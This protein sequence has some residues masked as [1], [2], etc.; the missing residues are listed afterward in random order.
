M[1]RSSKGLAAVLLL[2]LPA[3]PEG[4]AAGNDRSRGY[5]IGCGS[6]DIT[7]PVTGVP[8]WGFVRA[9]QIGRGL[10][11]RQRAR[12]FLVIDEHDSRLVLIVCD[13]GSITQELT[14]E[15]LDRLQQEFGDLY[16]QRNVILSA[17]HTHAAPAGFW[18]AGVGTPFGTPFYREYF[19]NIVD[20]VVSAVRHAHRTARP[21]RILLAR[22]DVPDAGVN[23]SLVAYM[24]N[25]AEERA[26]YSG[27]TDTTMT[28][29]RFET[30][31]GPIGCLNWFAVHPTTMTYHNRLVSGDNKG[32]AERAF[33]KA[34]GV[35]YR[36][37]DDFV[38]AFAQSNCGDVTG[39]LNL[40]NTGPGETEFETTRIIGHRQYAVARELFEQAEDELHGP[41]VSRQAWVDLS[42]VRVRPEFTGGSEQRTAPAAWGYAFAAGSTEDG[43]GHPLFREGMTEPV[44]LLE[45]TL[46]QQ[47]PDARPDEQLR[48]LHA[49]KAILLAPGNN[50]PQAG[51][52]RPVSLTVARLGPLVLAAGPAEFT[53]MAGR[54][55]RDTLR[56]VCG[57]E[58]VRDVVIA[59]YSNGYAGYVTTREEYETQQYE[60]GHTL[61]GPWTLAA[62]RQ[63]FAALA[64]SLNEDPVETPV[65]DRFTDLRG[66]VTSAP[67]AVG[68]DT[69]PAAGQFGD[70][71]LPPQSAYRRGQTVTVSFRTVNPRNHY[72]HP[73][74]VRVERQ[75]AAG[76]TTAAIDADWSVRVEFDCDDA[77]P[78]A[79]R[80]TVHWTPENDSPVGTCRIVHTGS[81]RSEADGPEQS[82]SGQT[83][84]F[85]LDD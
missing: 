25:P 63:E 16:T 26:R 39:N 71:L 21:G 12:A 11:L 83:E 74:F 70:V 84:P 45:F 43:G 44:P 77:S 13:L 8:F 7:G 33:E 17:T 56:R 10:H 53:T 4:T 40:D 46:D 15:V 65:P 24:N 49:P 79:C 61:F 34:E 9:D 75:E 80:M 27:S 18:H 72:P 82:F 57:P 37:P 42:C 69:P 78:G 54:R 68:P 35:L 23:R 59:G 52:G 1:T 2:V 73:E 36:R 6:A 67:L 81:W 47:F 85:R 41:V 5:R 55:I 50:M 51:V 58:S 20:G 64:A 31:D 66:Q 30:A 32:Y 38:A 19:R 3:I 14:L 28:L 62:Y 29:L 48:K 22:G 76:W 60:G